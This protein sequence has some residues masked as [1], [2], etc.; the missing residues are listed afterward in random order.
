MMVT[1]HCLPDT[2][3]VFVPSCS[4]HPCR[5]PANPRLFLY[6]QTH[7]PLPTLIEV[8]SL[9]IPDI[10]PSTF[11]KKLWAS[12]IG[13]EEMGNYLQTIICLHWNC[14]VMQRITAV[15]FRE[16]DWHNIVVLSHVRPQRRCVC[17]SF[18]RKPVT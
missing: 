6:V 9:T 10:D 17:V 4:Q 14:Y 12:G 11:G 18:R 2:T 7:Y 5:W 1:T 3:G 8:S 13:K 15:A 16:F